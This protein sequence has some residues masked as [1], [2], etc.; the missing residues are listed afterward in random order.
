MVCDELRPSPLY[1]H[2]LFAQ[3]DLARVVQGMSLFTAKSRARPRPKVRRRAGASGEGATDPV[4]R[5]NGDERLAVSKSLPHLHAKDK[6]TE[7]IG[8]GRR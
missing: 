1:P 3:H 2:F 5:G 7:N 4:G 8:K 6:R